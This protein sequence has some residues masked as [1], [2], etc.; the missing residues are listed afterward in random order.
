MVL[1]LLIGQ[2]PL[3]LL[4]TLL[5]ALYL[6]YIELRPLALGWRVK[7]WWFLLVFLTHFVGYLALRAY[8]ARRRPA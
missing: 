7:L 1:F 2:V 6:T 5:L 8:V 3:V 4:L